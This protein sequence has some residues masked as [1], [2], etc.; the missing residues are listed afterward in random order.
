MK[1]VPSESLS[2]KEKLAL[3]RAE[4]L[5][6]M[7]D[8][9][10]GRLDGSIDQPLPEPVR[11]LSARGGA[12]FVSRWWRRHPVSSALELL[13]PGLERYARRNPARLVGY[14]AGFGSLL[15]VLRPWRLLSLGAAVALVFKASNIAGEVASAIRTPAEPRVNP[16]G[17]D[18]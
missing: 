1:H 6:A 5:A 16:R 9:G 4:L 18:A 2:P 12:A 17:G 14:G 7:G 11:P 10:G 13:E 3:S 15:V 8:P